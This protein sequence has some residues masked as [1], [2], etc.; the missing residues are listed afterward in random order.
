[1]ESKIPSHP[2]R[3]PNCMKTLFTLVLLLSS[4]LVLGQNVGWIKGTI[5]DAQTNE[6]LPFVK[7]KLLNPDS[8]FN[9]GVLADVDGVYLFKDI[10]PGT[11]SLLFE[12]MEFKTA[13]FSVSVQPDKIT[14]QDVKLE[15]EV[16]ELEE[17]RVTSMA[18]QR[19]PGVQISSMQVRSSRARMKASNY[20]SPERY[21]KITENT[22]TAVTS[23]PLS[24]FSID[25]DRASYSNIRRFIEDGNIPPID[26]V[27]IEEMVNYFPY[28]YPTPTDGSPFTV[29]TEYTDCPWNPAHQLVKIGL[30][31]QTIEASKAAPNN[32]VFLID[33]SGSMSSE[34]KLPLL[35]KGL[36]ML[37]DQLREEDRVSIV[38]YAGAA[39]I[40]LPPTSGML[41]DKIKAVI[42]ELTSGGSTAGGEGIELAY[43]IAKTQF[44]ENGNNRVILAT[45][46][47]F[48][49]GV[50][51]DGDLVR[52]I[53]EK[54][55]QGIFLSVLGFG[56]GNLQDAKMEQLADKGNGNY[57]YI[58]NILEAKKVLVEEMGGTLI[59]VAKD[60]KLQ[61]EFNPTV[62]KGY[63]LIGYENRTLADEAFNN[64]KVDAGDL[65]AGHSV[66]AIYELIP[67]G[68]TE[69]LPGVDSLKYQTT[70]IPNGNYGNELMTVKVRYKA[71]AGVVSKLFTLP[72]KASITPFNATS[73]DMKFV[74]AVVEFG[75]LLRNSEFKGQAN[76]DH[77]IETA[78]NALGDEKNDY[79]VQ[80]V[81]LVRSA[82]ALVGKH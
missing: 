62:V 20:D 31:S 47:D 14:F 78:Q 34:D 54:R 11:Y 76:F 22:F 69:P 82:K 53:E 42:E 50:S 75:L 12:G 27:R 33:V 65:G 51:S 2:I 7:V 15:A 8:T 9:T 77:V 68:S 73:T 67:A 21:S 17:I 37:V 30:Q 39:G 28:Q 5:T 29:H 61:V 59:T 58:D 56:R 19:L 1:M 80:F 55:E 49:V 64:D 4:T 72:V 23:D 48:N 25:V 63:R 10:Q 71:P 16:K 44:L 79:R 81:T 26:A 66:T 57:N 13:V 6:P 41:K 3:K 60:V 18:I 40:V 36:Y 35:K 70:T 24:T 52:L 43:M 32:L 46:G 45:D 38:V 74:T